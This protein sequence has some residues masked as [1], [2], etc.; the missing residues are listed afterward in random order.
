M[1]LARKH[2]HAAR[3]ERTRRRKLKRHRPRMRTFT[4]DELEADICKQSF[5]DFVQ[6]MWEEIIA[7]PPVWNWHIKYLC[8]ELQKVGE[9]VIGKVNKSGKRIRFPK[10]YDLC[11]NVPP[12]STKSTIASVMFTPWL[13]ANDPTITTIN[14]S[15]GDALALDLAGK[16]A[17]VIESEKYQRLFPQVKMRR[18]AMSLMENDAGGRRIATSTGGRITGMH[19]DVIIIDD[20]INPKDAI[21]D[22]MIKGANEWFDHTLQSRMKDKKITPVITI[23]QRLREN[24]PS[25]HQLK[26]KGGVPVRHINLPAE[27][28]PDVRPRSLRANY[29]D[30]LFDPVRLPWSVLK[31]IKSKGEY[32]YAGQYLQRPI[33]LGGGMFKTDMIQ[34]ESILPGNLRKNKVIRFWDK[35]GTGGAGAFTVGVLMAMT[36]DNLFWIID[37]V[38]GQWE[39]NARERIIRQTAERDGRNVS[40]GIE[41]EPG[42]GG[43]DSAKMTITNLRGFRV[44]AERPVG[45]KVLRAD[46]FSAQVNA[47]NVR[48]LKGHWNAE[49]LAELGYFPNSEFKD[50]VDASS[51]GFAML[52]N[53]RR[54]V[55]AF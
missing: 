14:G 7:E 3:E 27:L 12:A 31:A 20:P 36:M 33:P 49:Y 39:S 55:G 54:A 26:Q 38:R 43:K 17:R 23:M 28:T 32:P 29:K 48:M 10:E 6:S 4:R 1:K 9:R 8:D 34:I 35:A 13:W 41:Q 51:A 50:Q 2:K 11:I 42:S 22:V 16:T 5:F 21:S 44:K 40:I 25:G 19:A 18:T 47:G 46:P 30:R 24:D 45:D 53:I 15:Y 52:C 37:V